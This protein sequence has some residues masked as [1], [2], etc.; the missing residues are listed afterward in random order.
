ML[1]ISDLLTSYFFAIW[2]WV[3]LSAAKSFLIFLTCAV[4]SFVGFFFI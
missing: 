3:N 2:G 4:V 1:E